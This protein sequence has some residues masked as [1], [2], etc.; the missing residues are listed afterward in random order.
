[1]P[2]LTSKPKSVPAYR[3]RA[4][5]GQA[6]V[7]LTD[8][9]TKKR[10]DY[11]LGAYDTPASRENYHRLIAEWEARG[12]RLPAPI[13]GLRRNDAAS[14][15]TFNEL[16]LE[17]WTFA[18]GYYGFKAAGHIRSVI[19]L[20]RRYYGNQPGTS[21]GPTALRIVREAMIKGDPASTPPRKPW[22]RPY[23]NS[24]VQRLCRMFKWGASHELVP[25]ETFHGLKT[26][27][28]LRRGRSA[29]A[30]PPPVAPVAVDLVEAIR[31]YV[32]R[33][34]RAL[35][36]LQLLTGA[37]GGELFKLRP[38]DIRIDD[39]QGIWTITLD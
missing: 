5:Y 12:R 24:Q 3:Q 39:R 33:Q 37:R 20:A 25:A 6:L 2:H 13:T 7:T 32:S 22:S 16:A 29:A 26:V 30:E 15:M 28:A 27:T 18:E 35:M 31:P 10:R 14:S 17:Y 36:D 19:R 21:F 1:M 11:W 38:I 4:G 8:S 9:V 23:V 34:V